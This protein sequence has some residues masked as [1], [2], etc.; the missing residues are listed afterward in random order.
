MIGKVAEWFMAPVL[1]TGGGVKPSVGSNPTLTA[2]FTLHPC[3]LR[4]AL[5]DLEK[6]PV[7]RVYTV[8]DFEEELYWEWDEKCL[9]KITDI[10]PPNR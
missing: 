7:P 6:N 10:S 5:R 9:S 1:K 2:K 8:D 3:M 4:R